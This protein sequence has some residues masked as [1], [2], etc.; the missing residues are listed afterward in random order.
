MKIFLKILPAFLLLLS[1]A[2]KAQLTVH[3]MVHAGYAYQNQSFG[4]VG[5]RLLFLTNDD[6]LFRV[7]AAAMMGRLTVSLLLC[8]KYRQIFY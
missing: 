3:P 4:E 6:T 8:Q 7:G 1:V 5:G 2:A